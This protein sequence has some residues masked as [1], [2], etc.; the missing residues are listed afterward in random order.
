MAKESWKTREA[1]AKS[2]KKASAKNTSQNTSQKSGSSRADYNRDFFNSEMEKYQT[3]D[4]DTFRAASLLEFQ[5]KQ[6]GRR[7]Q[8]LYDDFNRQ[9][10]AFD[11]AVARDLSDENYFNAAQYFEERQK[12]ANA[13]K[14]RADTLRLFMED[15][16]DLYTPEFYDPLMET[17]STFDTHVDDVLAQYKPSLESK[18]GMRAYEDE[19]LAAMERDKKL[20]AD[21]NLGVNDN[22]SAEQRYRLGLMQMTDP[23]EAKKYAAAVNAGQDPYL[24]YQ[25][26]EQQK[27]N[28]RAM[29]LVAEKREIDRLKAELDNYYWNSDYDATS[30]NERNAFD[31]EIK[32]R[33]KEISDREQ[34]YNLAKREQENAQFQ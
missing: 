24:L 1:T 33:E 16:M 27:A 28:W 10:S 20:N 22:W 32:R 7:G 2:Q 15:H 4:R 23:N 9:A 8:D 30:V 25:Q 19:L 31:Q 14:Q 29:D 13:L 34:Q 17:M 6:A 5:Q 26:Q 11:R 12:Q 21:G 3:Y 18:A